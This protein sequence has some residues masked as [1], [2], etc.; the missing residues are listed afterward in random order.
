MTYICGLGAGIPGGPRDPTLACDWCSHTMPV[1]AKMGAMPSW[2]ANSRAPRGW[3][4]SRA[5]DVL[6][7]MCPN[8]RDGYGA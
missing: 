1:V 2:L 8:C 7:H 4:V 5:L 6:H 3:R